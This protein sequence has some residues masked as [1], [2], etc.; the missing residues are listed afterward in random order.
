V[1]TDTA[2]FLATL[3]T[4][5]VPVPEVG[6]RVD[7]AATLVIVGAFAGPILV[8]RWVSARSRDVLSPPA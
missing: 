5:F 1:G 4:A 6:A 3:S 7:V 2:I 8:R